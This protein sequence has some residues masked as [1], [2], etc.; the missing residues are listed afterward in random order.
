MQALYDDAVRHQ[1]LQQRYIRVLD[2]F[3]R[4]PLVFFEYRNDQQRH[5]PP[6]RTII[7]QFKSIAFVY[8]DDHGRALD[9]GR[10]IIVD[11][12]CV[13]V[14]VQPAQMIGKMD[15][16]AQGIPDAQDVI[17]HNNIFIR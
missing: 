1:R 14:Y 16:V 17:F 3:Y 10:Y 12:A 8:L 15:L 6:D 5:F 2:T 13:S 4:T 7:V 9:H 11:I